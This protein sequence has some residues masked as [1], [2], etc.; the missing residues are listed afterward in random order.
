LVRGTQ[1]YAVTGTVPRKKYGDGH[2]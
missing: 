1:R 2:W